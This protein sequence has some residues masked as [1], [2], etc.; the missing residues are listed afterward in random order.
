M[1]CRARRRT[2]STSLTLPLMSLTESSTE[3]NSERSGAQKTVAISLD[4]VIANW[5][6]GLRSH[7]AT[8]RGVADQQLPENVSWHLAEWGI[9]DSRTTL[10]E[11]MLS[12]MMGRLR[13]MDGAA[14][15][16]ARLREAGFAVL[17][18]TR[19]ERMAGDDPADK[20]AARETTRKW[21][22]GQPQLGIGDDDIVFT[23]DPVS[24]DADIWVDDSP[25]RAERLLA[26]GKELWMLPRPWNRDACKHPEINILYEGWSSVGDLI[27]HSR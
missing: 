17:V 9:T 12:P 18:L 21:F 14:T 24:A 19:R 11:F 7:V 23:D 5:V 8:R 1:L 13:L 15:G 10:R 16:I 25:Q 22:A 20:A 3:S 26:A 2:A 27:S 4:G 6:K